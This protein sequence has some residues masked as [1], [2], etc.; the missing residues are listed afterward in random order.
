MS[1]EACN[2]LLDHKFCSHIIKHLVISLGVDQEG[3]SWLELEIRDKGL[4]RS[5]KSF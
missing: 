2:K 4:E 3:K 1:D 5:K